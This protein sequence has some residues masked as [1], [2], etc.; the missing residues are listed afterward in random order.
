MNILNPDEI[1]QP[2][3]DKLLL[4]FSTSSASACLSPGSD[5]FTAPLQNLTALVEELLP[6]PQMFPIDGCLLPSGDVLL[7]PA[8]QP[9]VDNALYPKAEDLLPLVEQ[10]LPLSED[11]LPRPEL[12]KEDAPK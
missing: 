2:A 10:L 4:P 6:R 3:S 5:A 9:R 11:L 8:D 12:K 1:L 7:P